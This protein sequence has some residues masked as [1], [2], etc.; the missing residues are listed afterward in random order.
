MK[1]VPNRAYVHEAL[2]SAEIAA[3]SLTRVELCHFLVEVRRILGADGPERIIRS[4]FGLEELS[5]P[6]RSIDQTG[7][8]AALQY[9][10]LVDTVSEPSLRNLPIYDGWKWWELY[11]RW[12]LFVGTDRLSEEDEKRYRSIISNRKVLHDAGAEDSDILVGT[13][14]FQVDFDPNE[15]WI[16]EKAVCLLCDVS[17]K[18]VAELCSREDVETCKSDY[19]RTVIRVGAVREYLSTSD[20]FV[21][22]TFLDPDDDR[23]K[24]A[25]DR[26]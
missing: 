14:R 12:N 2:K 15:E 4:Y 21:P 19:V 11:A 9:M 20:A 8:E 26:K 6:V 16:D 22:T 23:I 1:A 25:T 17:E 3:L 18:T 13:Y 7:A 10:P 24:S 5:L